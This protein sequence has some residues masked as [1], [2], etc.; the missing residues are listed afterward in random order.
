LVIDY[1]SAWHVAFLVCLDLKNLAF[2]GAIWQENLTFDSEHRKLLGSP[3]PNLSGMLLLL[4]STNCLKLRR[5]VTLS[6]HSA[7]QRN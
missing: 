1:S 5:T 3:G 2:L 4:N 7:C 6:Y